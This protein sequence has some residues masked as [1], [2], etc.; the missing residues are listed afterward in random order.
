MVPL[1]GRKNGATNTVQIGDKIN[2]LN[3]LFPCNMAAT[4]DPEGI[5]L[6]GTGGEYSSNI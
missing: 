6:F 4:D 1:K 5:K 2:A 3:Y